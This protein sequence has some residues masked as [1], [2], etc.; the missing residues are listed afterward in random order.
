MRSLGRILLAVMTAF[1]AVCPVMSEEFDYSQNQKAVPQRVDLTDYV[2]SLQAKIQ[3]SWVPPEVVEQGHTVVVFK[4]DRDGN[5]IHSYVKESSGDSLYDVSALESI[6]KASPFAAVPEGYNRDTITM[7]YS[8]KSSVVSKDEIKEL[9]A[10]SERYVN[11]D[12]SRALSYIDEAIRTIQGDPAAYFLYARRAKINKLMGN[13]DAAKRDTEESKRLKT[14]YNNQRID[15]CKR[16]LLAEE[17]PFAYFTLA[18]AYELA[19]DYTNAL[20][21]IDKAISM[22]D[23]NHAYKRYRA[24][25][26]MRSK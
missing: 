4:L 14:V 1:L 6:Q 13:D 17:T 5:V 25:I 9:V 20:Q 16:A 2:T 18:N 24:E 26:I 3:K 19:G 11:S 23:L 15:K 22:T 10:K 12:N 21:N 8:F 7:Q